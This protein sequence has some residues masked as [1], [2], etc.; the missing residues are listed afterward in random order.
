MCMALVVVVAMM[1]V[2]F[3]RVQQ[4]LNRLLFKDNTVEIAQINTARLRVNNVIE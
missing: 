3:I 2:W 1:S 4:R